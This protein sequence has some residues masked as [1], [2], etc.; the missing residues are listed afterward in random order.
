MGAIAVT[1][2]DPTDHALAA[3][4]SILDQPEKRAFEHAAVP[5]RLHEIDG[6]SKTGPGPYN[7]LR[8]KW[9]ARAAGNGRYVV[10][11]TIGD[12]SATITSAPMTGEA[13]IQFID[14]RE[15]AARQRFEQ[16]K[17]EMA[18]RKSAD[19]DQPNEPS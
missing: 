3:I 14:E 11:E 13:A 6:Y 12:R 18:G 2:T 10:D 1:S 17:N 8:V 9:A 5:A 4:A 16:L 19:R 15:Q 7:A